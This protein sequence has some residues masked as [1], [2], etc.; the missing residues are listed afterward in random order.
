P[1]RPRP[2][3][4]VDAE[5]EKHRGQR[6]TPLKDGGDAAGMQRMHR[7]ENCGRK[8]Y[9]QRMAEGGRNLPE[10]GPNQIEHKAGI[11]SMNQD[12]DDQV[13]SDV[14]RLESDGDVERM[15]ERKGDDR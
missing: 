3:I 13:R 5:Q 11:Q 7:K 10:Q 15:V 12:I 4:S 1:A 2:Q 8:R 9:P 14:E 6:S